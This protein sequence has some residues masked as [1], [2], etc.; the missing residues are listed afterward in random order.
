MTTYTYSQA[1]QNFAALLEKAKQEG[2]VL[3]KRKDGSCFVVRPFVTKKSP[4]DVGGVD[5]DISTD[6]IIEAIREVRERS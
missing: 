5:I 3:I 6:E 4:L 2:E 1:R